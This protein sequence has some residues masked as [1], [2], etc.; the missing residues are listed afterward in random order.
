MFHF[1]GFKIS[2]LINIFSFQ[3]RND[4]DKFN[5]TRSQL[6]SCISWLQISLLSAAGF[7]TAG[8]SLLTAD[9]V[10]GHAWK[11]N[12][13]TCCC[14]LVT[15]KMVH[16]GSGRWI[17]V[18]NNGGNLLLQDTTALALSSVPPVFK[19]EAVVD[20]FKSKHSAVKLSLESCINLLGIGMI[21]Y[22]S[23]NE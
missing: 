5:C 4:F 8:S 14:G 1:V 21:V 2:S 17:E 11:P 20:L 7:T 16:N 15:V 18:F 6:E 10:F 12:R 22:K 3:A 23:P 19:E 9:T 13:E